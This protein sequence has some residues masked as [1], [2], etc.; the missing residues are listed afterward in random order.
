MKHLPN[1]LTCSNLFCGIL[2]IVYVCLGQIEPVLWLMGLSLLFDFF[3]GFAARLVGVSSP[4]GKELDSLA[5]MVSF[6]VVPGMIMAR[7]IREAQ[8]K[9]FLPEAPF[10]LFAEIP[11]FLVAFLITVFSAL[12]LAKFN[13][14]TRQSDSFYGLPTPANTLLIA[15]FWM[16]LSFSP[17][18]LL[19]KAL[20]NLWV[21][22]GLSVL[23]SFLL[24]ADIKLIALKF[25][26]FGWKGNEFRFI[27][28][29]LSILLFAFLLHQAIP[30]LILIYFI[31]SIVQNQ[32]DNKD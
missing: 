5:D 22:M 6:G 26:S 8:G 15:S 19:A 14:D 27:L 32:L 28:I 23:S 16:I 4:V 17:D 10:E 12:R 9:A 7:M 2:A 18:S 25:K 1:L 21:L 20:Q 11:L 13:L 24:V 31:L 30:I 29:G 3:D